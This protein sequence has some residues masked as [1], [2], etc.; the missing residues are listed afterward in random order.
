[1]STEKHFDIK[2]WQYIQ[3]ANFSLDKSTKYIYHYVIGL[4]NAL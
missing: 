2:I 1:M 4:D 3:K